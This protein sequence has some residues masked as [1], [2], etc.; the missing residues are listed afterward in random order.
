MHEVV[1]WLQFAPSDRL[2][3]Y[4]SKTRLSLSHVAWPCGTMA[5]GSL[6]LAFRELDPVASGARRPCRP[7]AH[8][9]RNEIIPP[10]NSLSHACGFLESQPSASTGQAT[11]WPQPGLLDAK[12]RDPRGSITSPVS[13]HLGR[14]TWRSQRT[15]LFFTFHASIASACQEAMAPKGRARGV[16]FPCR[17]WSS[18][19]KALPKA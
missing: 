16:V 18:R 9:R 11:D 10:A 2:Y 1:P 19:N 4:A 3:F 14:Q 6:F 12:S 13:R 7:C 8:R 17:N 15:F 5:H